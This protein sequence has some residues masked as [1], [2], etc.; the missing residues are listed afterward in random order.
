VDRIVAELAWQLKEAIVERIPLV[1]ALIAATAQAADAVLVHR[2]PHFERIPRTLVDQVVLQLKTGEQ[3]GN[4]EQERTPTPTNGGN[5]T[6][7]ASA[8]SKKLK[9]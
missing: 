2:D 1:D 7:F 9:K 3:G 6:A 8:T 4:R 5:V